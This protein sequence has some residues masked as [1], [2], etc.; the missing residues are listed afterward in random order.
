MAVVNFLISPEAQ[1]QKADPTVWGDGTILAMDKLPKEVRMQFDS[2]PNRVYAPKRS[3]IQQNALME[4]APEY[5]I[6]LAEDFRT[7]IIEQ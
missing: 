3:D 1:L 7:K 4:L 6:R 5:M 2:I